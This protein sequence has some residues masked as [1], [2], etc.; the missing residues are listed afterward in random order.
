[1][2]DVD[3]ARGE[4]ILDVAQR[5]GAPRISSRPDGSLRRA[6]EKSEWVALALKRPPRAGGELALLTDYARSGIWG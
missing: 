2:V 6:V 5:K 3:P 1:M 4:E